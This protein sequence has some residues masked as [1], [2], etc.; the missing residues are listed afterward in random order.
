MVIA[1]EISIPDYLAPK[2]GYQGPDPFWSARYPLSSW[3]V[4]FPTIPLFKFT[5]DHWHWSIYFSAIYVAAIVVGKFA[6]R[7]REPFDLKWALVAWNAVLSVFSLLGAAI[8][9]PICLVQ[10]Y[11]G[12][13]TCLLC[14][15]VPLEIRSR[16]GLWTILYVWSKVWEFGDTGFLVLRKRPVI[17]LHWIHHSI[18]CVVSFFNV[19]AVNVFPTQVMAINYR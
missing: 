10:L 17:H 14:D 16:Y 4:Y 2:P 13:L 8:M 9:V 15:P 12:G 18:T 1:K 7:H 6:M 11:R 3:E 5:A 19:S